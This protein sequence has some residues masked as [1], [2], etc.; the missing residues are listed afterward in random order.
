MPKNQQDFPKTHRIIRIA[1][2]SCVC[3][4]QWKGGRPCNPANALGLCEVVIPRE[5]RCCGA[6]PVHG[7]F[8]AVARQG[9]RANIEA[10]ESLPAAVMVVNSAGCGAMLKEYADLFEP[11][12]PWRERAVRFQQAVVGA[13]VMRN[14]LPWPR[15]AQLEP[16]VTVYDPCH[17][18]R[19]PK[20]F[21]RTRGNPC[22]APDTRFGGCPNRTAVADRPEFTI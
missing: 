14:R 12:D 15:V 18:A 22:G 20:G 10:F 7:G 13:T 1:K 5:Q 11:G 16:T 2:Q 4:N 9:A 3:R 17:L 19:M 6:L 21:A 8:P